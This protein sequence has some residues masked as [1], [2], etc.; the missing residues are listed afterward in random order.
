MNSHP[1]RFVAD[2]TWAPAPPVRGATGA[3]AL[4]WLRRL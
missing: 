4:C 1:T 2:A 3:P